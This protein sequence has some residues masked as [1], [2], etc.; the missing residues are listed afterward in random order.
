MQDTIGFLN[1]IKRGYIFDFPVASVG[2]HLFMLPF[3]AAIGLD[4]LDQV[5][6]FLTGQAGHQG[7][8]ADAPRT[9]AFA[10]GGTERFTPYRIT[11]GRRFTRGRHL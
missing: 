10:T 11:K 5:Y 6:R 7:I 8:V 1:G 4:G 3:L 2:Y 9:M